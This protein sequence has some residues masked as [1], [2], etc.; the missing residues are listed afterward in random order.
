MDQ[1]GSTF[2]YQVLQVALNQRLRDWGEVLNAADQFWS[3]LRDMSAQEFKFPIAGFGEF[4]LFRLH[5]L[6]PLMHFV[7][8]GPVDNVG[9]QRQ[10]TTIHHSNLLRDSAGMRFV[11]TAIEVLKRVCNRLKLESCD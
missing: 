6:M 10:Q 9:L 11:L 7:L 4:Q 8:T 1:S 2:G 5:R 3:E